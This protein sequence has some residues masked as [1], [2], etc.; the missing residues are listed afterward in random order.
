MCTTIHRRLNK[1]VNIVNKLF[2]GL[3]FFHKGVESDDSTQTVVS[4][5][6]LFRYEQQSGLEQY[7]ADIGPDPRTMKSQIMRF[8]DQNPAYNYTVQS[9]PDPTFGQADTDDVG[10]SEFF[11]RPLKIATFEWGTGTFV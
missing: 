11:Y 3:P 5:E 8:D 1:I 2:C 9:E 7:N 10:L 4:L 6:E